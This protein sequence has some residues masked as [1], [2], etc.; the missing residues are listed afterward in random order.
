MSASRT[1]RLFTTLAVSSL[2]ALSLFRLT[3]EYDD[4]ESH[5]FTSQ[6]L[7]DWGLY[8]V[9]PHVSYKSFG[10]TPPLL[11]FLTW[12]DRCEDGG[13]YLLSMRGGLVSK[14]GPV[15]MDDRGDL[16]WTSDRFGMVTDVKTQTYR[17]SEY[18]TFWSGSNG[19]SR[20]FGAGIYY[21]V[22]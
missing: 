19:N 2:V 13:L 15:I 10:L 1:A 11:D 5:V 14:P 18:L 22:N 9:I 12:D 8:G 6:L 16:V 3:T 20:S 4:T 7:Y 17:G 21:M